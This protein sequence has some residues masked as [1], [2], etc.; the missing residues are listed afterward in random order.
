M[1]TI[2]MNLIDNSKE[3]VCKFC[4]RMCK[5]KSGLAFHQNRCHNNPCRIIQSEVMNYK[6]IYQN[7]S[8]EAKDRMAWSRGK[9]AKTDRSL[10][11][12]SERALKYYQTHEGTFKGKHHTI[13]T[14]LKIS[15]SSK[16]YRCKANIKSHNYSEKACN[17]IDNLNKI[18]GWK[19]QHALN[20][21][22][23]KIL[24]YYVDGYDA[25]HNIVFEYDDSR[26]H[27]KSKFDNVLSNKDLQ[28]QE[29]ILKK[30]KCRFIRYNPYL[31]ILYNAVNKEVI[32][33]K[34]S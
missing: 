15:N 12:A 25:E 3:L 2:K 14:K 13:S 34:R 18:F 5:N 24:N 10:K 11:Q 21:G 7:R 22:E 26:Y 29:N 27:Y 23:I 9:T 6:A 32:D 20:G 33:Y 4:G 28:R 16:Q 30:L 19:L 8:Q 31:D 17:F 1:D